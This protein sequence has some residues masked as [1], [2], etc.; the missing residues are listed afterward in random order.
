WTSRDGSDGKW[1]TFT[2]RVGTPSQLM[3]VHIAIG[4]QETWVVAPSG[5]VDSDPNGDQCPSKRGGLFQANES[6]TW[7]STTEIWDNTGIYGLGEVVL[8]SLGIK[9]QGQYGFDV[10]GLN[11][12]KVN[13]NR[14]IVAQM[15][16]LNFY[17]GQFGVSP[18]PTNFTTENNNASSMND[19]QPSFFSLLRD[20]NLIPSLTYSY[21]AGSYAR[22]GTLKNSWAS[23]IFGGYDAALVGPDELSFDFTADDGRELV[24]AIQSI[25]KSGSNGEAA[26][27]PTAVLAALDSSQAALW[28]PSEACEQ[29]ENAFGIAWND[30]LEMYLVNGTA[31]EALVEE[32]PNVT[33]TLG[34]AVEGGRTVDIV[35]PYSAFDL[36]A[37]YPTISG[38]GEERFFP[39]KRA[40]NSSQ[41]TLG[42]TFLQEAYLVADYERHNFSLSQRVWNDSAP[43]DII[44]IRS[45]NSGSDS[46][47]ALS[48][49]AI[50]GI[51]VGAAAI[52]AIV[53]VAF[54]I[55][56]RRSRRQ[57]ETRRTQLRSNDALSQFKAVEELHGDD[58]R[59]ELSAYQQQQQ[60]RSE[61]P[62]DGDKNEMPANEEI[63]RHVEIDGLEAPAELSNE[64]RSVDPQELPGDYPASA[65][66]LTERN[67]STRK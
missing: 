32:N 45:V 18:R 58:H 48:I 25:Q 67:R 22:I 42:R 43:S 31:H 64:R 41:I 62:G 30:T 37:T 17:M 3:R 66:E 5:C 49:G 55:V 19:P 24:V 9:G 33:F 27:L 59:R 7:Q 6:S 53:L 15:N 4:G 21:T 61:L 28:L 11:A 57:A 34:N 12:G 29:F 38:S 8:D 13:L 26:L 46:G 54:C 14:T 35:L 39:L 52:A 47:P 44:S 23:F 20:N 2:L 1:S 50:I 51:V 56:R 65:M 10:V 63:K 36:N 40:A 60:H 16:T